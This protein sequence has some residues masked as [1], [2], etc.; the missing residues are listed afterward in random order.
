MGKWAHSVRMSEVHTAKEWH[1]T[2]AE[3]RALPEED[4]AEMTAFEIAKANMAAYENYLAY[5]KMK[6]RSSRKKPGYSEF[7]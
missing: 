7:E 2:P 5:V 3:F 6:N 1:M 4:K